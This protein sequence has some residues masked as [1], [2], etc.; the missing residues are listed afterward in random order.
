MINPVLNTKNYVKDNYCLFA[1]LHFYVYF[2]FSAVSYCYCC[3]QHEYD[4]SIT[5][6]LLLCKYCLIDQHEVTFAGSI[7]AS[8]HIFMDE[9]RLK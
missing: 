6:R 1:L 3:W 2:L 5:D 4:K 8:L 9:C 7:G